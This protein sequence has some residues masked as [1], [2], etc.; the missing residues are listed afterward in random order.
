VFSIYQ[1]DGEAFAIPDAEIA[2][3]QRIVASQYPVELYEL[4]QT[5][6]VVEISDD[7]RGVLVERGVECRVA[8]GFDVIGRTVV[9]RVPLDSV[10]QV[11]KLT[12]HWS[13]QFP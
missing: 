8:I 3:L 2:C 10:R 12:P 13:L 4:P 9:I 5:G 11:D 1:S 7:V 6:D